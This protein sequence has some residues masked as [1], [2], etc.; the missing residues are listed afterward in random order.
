[1][2]DRHECAKTVFTLWVVMWLLA[3][4]ALIA[5]VSMPDFRHMISQGVAKPTY[6]VALDQLAIDILRVLGIDP[7]DPVSQVDKD[8]IQ[9][10]FFQKFHVKRWQ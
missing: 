7:E 10:Y 2:T 1:M 3:L 5:L 6:G 8:A 4:G 9:D